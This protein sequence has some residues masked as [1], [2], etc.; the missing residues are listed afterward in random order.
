MK[1]KGLYTAMTA[2]SLVVAPTLAAAAPVAT[3]LTQPATETVAGDNAFAGSALLIALL[4][5]AAV[6]AGIA[7]AVSHHDDKSPNAPTSP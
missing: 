5:V 2:L 7:A 3:P 6:G 1:F 4:A